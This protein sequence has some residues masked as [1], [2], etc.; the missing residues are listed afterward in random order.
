[1]GTY[2]TTLKASDI[3]KPPPDELKAR[4]NPYHW[5]LVIAKSG[6]ID[7]APALTI[8]SPQHG[9]LE[10]PTLSVSGDTLNLSKEFCT[11]P[12]QTFATSAYRW[13]LQGN[14]L[15]LTLTKP[16]CPDKVA[17]TILASEPWHSS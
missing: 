16:G 10:S 6:G 3:P 4:A 11:T 1:V 8:V 15:R 2:T 5:K 17:Q 12:G 13:Q 14:T 7:N 9:S